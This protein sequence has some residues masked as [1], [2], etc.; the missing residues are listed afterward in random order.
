M[1][2]TINNSNSREKNELHHFWNFIKKYIEKKLENNIYKENKD[3][4]YSIIDETL[5]N[6]LLN[7][8]LEE[9]LTIK[10]FQ[11]E[12]FNIANEVINNLREYAKN[13]NLGKEFNQI[14]WEHSKDVF[15]SILKWKEIFDW[16]K[17]IVSLKDKTNDYV[18]KTL[19]NS[20]S[21]AYKYKMWI[22]RFKELIKWLENEKQKEELEILIT[23]LE[24]NSQEYL[25]YWN[26]FVEFLKSKLEKYKEN[27]EISKILAIFEEIKNKNVLA[28]RVRWFHPDE[29][30]KEWL[31]KAIE[32]NISELEFDIR[33]SSD[34]KPII[35]HNASLWNSANRK[36]YIKDL[37]YDELKNIKLKN[38]GSIID[39][40]DFFELV[41]N[42]WN[43]STIINIDIKDFDKNWLDNI[44][45]LIKEY[46]FDHRVKI[47]SWSGQV[48]QYMYEKRPDLHYSLSY[49]PITNWIVSKWLLTLQDKFNADWI[50]AKLWTLVSEYRAWLVKS[51]GQEIIKHTRIE[52]W[53]EY[54]WDSKI[55]EK[56]WKWFHPMVAFPEKQWL[57][58]NPI[59]TRILKEG[60]VNIQAL[61]EFLKKMPDFMKEKYYKKLNK[62]IAE[63]KELWI[64]TN[65][66]DI[67]NKKVLEKYFNNVNSNWTVY[68]S[69]EKTQIVLGK[70]E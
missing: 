40:K 37:S 59:Y 24:D 19:K 9:N 68:S 14:L 64:E 52:N 53:K 55:Y 48:L 62:L 29:A 46:K 7:N 43:E 5:K 58:N 17:E 51:T 21:N 35:H 60:S 49:H 22:E 30:S 13:N 11:K 36:E 67:K 23:Q 27:E 47:V 2:N 1:E 57:Q 32:T 26:D 15:M 10:K 41:K 42:S 31:K 70:N 44:L 69:N 8:F 12:K 39:L 65:V 61:D 54:Y 56:W 3:N 16:E 50:L 33:F 6:Y 4:I 25:E 28:H 18:E 45:N 20:F 34:W 63:L 66:F 38:W